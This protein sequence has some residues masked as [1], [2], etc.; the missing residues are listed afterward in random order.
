[1]SNTLKSNVTIN[2]NT[3]FTLVT[4]SMAIFLNQSNILFGVNISYADFFCMVVLLTLV[5]KN[6]LLFPFA[7]T[8]FFLILSA[9]LLSSSIYYVPIK[10]LYYPEQ[11]N[12]MVN[13][14]KLLLTFLYFI[15]GYTLNN[16]ILI[17]KTIKWYSL[18]SL[19][20]GVVGIVFI[21][22]NIKLSETMFLDYRFKG[23]MNDPNYF[24]IIQI[25]AL[26][27]FSRVKNIKFINRR[28][29]ILLIFISIIASGSKT[30]LITLFCYIFFR[31][32]ESIIKQKKNARYFIMCIPIIFLMIFL[33]INFSGSLQGI[34]EHISSIIPTFSRLQFLFT[35]FNAAIFE[36]GSGRNTT[37]EV[38]VEIIKI[39]PI[40]GVGIGTYSGIAQKVFGTDSI[41]HN[42]YL[43]LFAEWGI[44]F[45]I[46]LFI[47]IFYII[48]RVTLDR[49]LNREINLILRDILIVFLIGSFAISLNNARMVWFFL[50][51]IAF[52]IG[53][54]KQKKTTESP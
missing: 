44:L 18:F 4:I 34:I 36:N 31:V 25:S 20:I 43:Q 2:Y 9:F 46:I 3:S 17:E 27:Y 50:G 37:W 52:N 14:I 8:V 51:I 28:V 13:Y 19:L 5:H 32:L 7:P 6:S 29:A 23:L 33:K 42:T 41:A 39:S 53:Q 11:T 35:D 40:M 49:K 54:N 24:S 15:I 38:A 47:Y 1:M 45:S 12:I 22:F 48:G 21:I 10:F 26:V 30:G 16:E